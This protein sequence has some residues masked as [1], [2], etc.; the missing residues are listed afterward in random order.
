[1]FCCSFPLQWYCV[2]YC[3]RYLIQNQDW[4]HALYN[5]CITFFP[6]YSYYCFYQ[7]HPAMGCACVSIIISPINSHKVKV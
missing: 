2:R 3:V 5:V 6:C 7:Y 1:M 4:V